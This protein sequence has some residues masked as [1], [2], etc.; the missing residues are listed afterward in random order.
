MAIELLATHERPE[1]RERAARD[2][3]ELDELIGELLLASRLDAQHVTD[4][5]EEVDVLALL[6]EETAHFDADVS[7]EPVRIRGDA[8]S[9]PTS[10]ASRYGFAETRGCS[11]ASSATCSRTRCAT[12]EARRSRPR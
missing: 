3:A 8:P 9:T 7:G 6:A 2:I 10:R 1:I 5:N 11:G 4:S 12:A